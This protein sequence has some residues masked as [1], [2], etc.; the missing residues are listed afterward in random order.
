MPGSTA[1]NSSK[2]ARTAAS[3]ATIAAASDVFEGSS[4]T[5][6]AATPSI[7]SAASRSRRRSEKRSSPANR[8]VSRVTPAS[9]ASVS[10]TSCG[11]DAEFWQRIPRTSSSVSGVAAGSLVSRCWLICP[12]RPAST[13]RPSPAPPWRPARSASRRSRYQCSGLRSAP[14]ALI[15]G[16]PTACRTRSSR[17]R[18]SRVLKVT[19]SLSLPTVAQVPPVVAEYCAIPEI[20]CGT[21]K[22]MSSREPKT[23]SSQP[24]YLRRNLNIAWES[25]ATG[26]ARLL[27]GS[28]TGGG[29]GRATLDQR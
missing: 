9:R 23:P 4:T 6:S 8:L 19:F 11:L 7:I 13:P 28:P 2:C 16:L 12:V 10:S 24:L 15:V 26:R 27:P 5:R 25:R 17:C 1:A 20:A 21:R 14:R 29:S 3:S 18:R 22:T